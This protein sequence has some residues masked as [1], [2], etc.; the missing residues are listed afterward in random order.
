M[1]AIDSARFAAT[2]LLTSIA[3]GQLRGARNLVESQ[4]VD[5]GALLDVVRRHAADMTPF[6]SEEA[7]DMVSVTAEG[8]RYRVR[9]PVWVEGGKSTLTVE[10][11]SFERLADYY[12]CYIDRLVDDVGCALL[13]EADAPASAYPRASG[14]PAS[15]IE[16]PGDPRI[17]RAGF[18]GVTHGIRLSTLLSGMERALGQPLQRLELLSPGQRAVYLLTRALDSIYGDGLHSLYLDNRELTP[19]LP[20]CCELVVAPAYADIFRR[21]N[22][23]KDPDELEASFYRLEDSGET[24]WEPMLAYIETHPRE[25]FTD[26]E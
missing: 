5:P 7:Y 15:L 17:R 8:E 10:L 1:D 3:L 25:F 20:E 23:G 6:P 11:I 12:T 13:V 21:G 26:A 19:E 9:T 2:S 14:Q 4:G 24:L 22:A 18:V 16:P